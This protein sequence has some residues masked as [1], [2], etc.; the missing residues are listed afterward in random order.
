MSDDRDGAAV[1]APPPA[2]PPRSDRRRNRARLL[3]AAQQVFAENGPDAALDDVARRAGV[4]NATLYR[5]FPTRGALLDELFTGRFAALLEATT[6][7]TG[8]GPRERLRAALLRVALDQTRDKAFA[9]A[10]GAL[11]DTMPRARTAREE[12]LAALGALLDQAQQDGT[13]HRAVTVE[14][15]RLAVCAI[16]GGVTLAGGTDDEQRFARTLVDGFLPAPG[17]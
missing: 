7:S 14:D 3:E 6:G 15:L 8:T 5:N 4:G 12:L 10:L 1:A 9:Y 13:V 11:V 17:G 2:R 16:A